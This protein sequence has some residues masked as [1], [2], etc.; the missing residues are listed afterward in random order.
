MPGQLV[1]LVLLPRFTTYS[2]DDDY[3]TIGMDVTAYSSAIINIWRNTLVGTSGN[4]DFFLEESS[5]Q[6]SWSLCTVTGATQPLHGT[7]GQE[8]QYVAALTKRWFRIR[9]A[10]PNANNIGTC[11]AVGF[12]EER[13]S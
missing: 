12:L 13:L 1:P 5:D 4:P 9:V 3:S 2:G 7:A 8:V 11:Y 6:V 10:L